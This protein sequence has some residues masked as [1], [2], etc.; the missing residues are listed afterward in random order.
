MSRATEKRTPLEGAPREFQALIDG[1]PHFQRHKTAAAALEEVIEYEWQVVS[2][3]QLVYSAGS[4]HHEAIVAR[5]FK[6]RNGNVQQ[7]GKTSIH[8][9]QPRS[10][11]GQAK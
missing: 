6:G 2:I 1:K 5:Y 10:H 11:G 9:T 4:W 3:L 7:M 8:T